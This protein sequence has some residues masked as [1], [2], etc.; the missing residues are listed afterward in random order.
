MKKILEDSSPHKFRRILGIDPSSKKIACTLIVDG[1]IMATVALSLG[2]G[3]IYERLF[4]VRKR[5]PHLLD[6]YQPDFVGI[7]QAIF[8]QNPATSRKLSYIVGVIIA[9]TLHKEIVLE[10][11]SPAEWKSFLGVK[12]LTKTKKNEII[13]RLGQTVGRKEIHNLKK[14]QTQ[15][16]LRDQY[17]NFV[18][19]DDDIADSCGIALYFWSKYGKI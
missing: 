15:N 16:I 10:D 5:Y 6:I 8:V 4:D 13:S 1:I 7:E 17:P 11:I 2:S 18:W 9:E 14:T 19:D 3:N 12:P